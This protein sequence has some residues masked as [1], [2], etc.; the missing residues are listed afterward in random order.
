MENNRERDANTVL[1][2]IGQDRPKKDWRDAT[3]TSPEFTRLMEEVE[4]IQFELKR[5][6]RDFTRGQQAVT[7]HHA[8]PE[9]RTLAPPVAFRNLRWSNASS[10]LRPDNQDG[11]EQSSRPLPTRSTPPRD[12]RS[13]D[14]LRRFDAATSVRIAPSA[15]REANV[16]ALDD[17]V[18]GF[19]ATDRYRSTI[20]GRRQ[21]QRPSPGSETDL[22]EDDGQFSDLDALDNPTRRLHQVLE[23]ASLAISAHQSLRAS[24]FDEIN[25]ISVEMDLEMSEGEFEDA[26][27][28]EE[29]RE[30]DD[31]IEASERLARE[32]MEQEQN[33][34]MESLYQRQRE[35]LERLRGTGGAVAQPF[36]D[37]SDDEALQEEDH[38]DD[39]MDYDQLL[40]LSERLGDVRTERWRQ[41]SSEVAASLTRIIFADMQKTLPMYK[42]EMCVICQFTFEASDEVKLM[43]NCTHAFHSD[44]ADGWIKDHDKCATCKASLE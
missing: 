38:A 39:G 8:E 31:D 9:S 16:E 34:L 17:L 20:S 41:K 3:N 4:R 36:L 27:A 13:H 35:E 7:Q 10:T 6:S 18:A 24:A 28:D 2:T 11:H 1:R 5:P 37:L 44:C 22:E 15:R 43:P 21:I 30:G 42:D 19:S 14:L 40:E 32:L 33:D 12:Q 26:T 29:V 23:S 25:D